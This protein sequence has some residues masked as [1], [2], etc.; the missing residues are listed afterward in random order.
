LAAEIA[1]YGE[2]RRCV[3]WKVERMSTARLI[4]RGALAGAGCAVSRNA[5]EAV[6]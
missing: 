1:L 5:G 4:T 2:L 6:R 3:M